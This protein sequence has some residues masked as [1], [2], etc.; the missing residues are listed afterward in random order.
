MSQ[1]TRPAPWGGAGGGAGAA[2]Q[3]AGGSRQA[4]SMRAHTAALRS[5]AAASAIWT[6]AMTTRSRG[7]GRDSSSKSLWIGYHPH[8]ECHRY[9]RHN[10]YYCHHH[11]L[12]LSIILTLIL[13]IIIIIMNIIVIIVIIIIIVIVTINI[14]F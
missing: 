1:A 12:H 2:R 9:Y 6:H 4:R 14:I 3:R 13:K 10:H 8:H 7:D 11:R 5:V